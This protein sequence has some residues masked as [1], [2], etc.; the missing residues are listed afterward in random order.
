MS[1]TPGK[2]QTISE[3]QLEGLE[4]KTPAKSEMQYLRGF[5]GKSSIF[6]AFRDFFISI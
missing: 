5:P 4:P 1:V 6:K 2:S 3:M